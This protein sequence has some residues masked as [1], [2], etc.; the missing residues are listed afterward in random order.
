MADIP[1]IAGANSL[2]SL[3]SGDSVYILGG[4]ATIDTNLDQSALA[5]GLVI[6]EV[7]KA[8]TGQFGS[9]AAP[10]YS[11]ITE[12][13]VYAAGAGSIY[14]KGKDGGDATPLVQC[15]GGGYFGFIDGTAT[16]FEVLSGQASIGAL[17]I[18]TN[19]RIAG[20]STMIHDDSSTDPTLLHLLPGPNGSGGTCETKRGGTTIINDGGQLTIDA[21]S[22]VITTL[23]CTGAAGVARTVLRKSGTITSLNALGHVPDVSQLA[24]PLTITNVNINMSLPGAQALLSHP[25]ITPGTTVQY[26]TDGR[27]I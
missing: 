7:G 8:Y 16:R 21:G 2:G 24:D 26:I 6:V 12:R 17:S 1:I 18:A 10:F 4:S 20:G 22:N 23:D 5:N 13:L 25:L 15:I 14:Y 11:E 3:S 19:I 9:A 27:P